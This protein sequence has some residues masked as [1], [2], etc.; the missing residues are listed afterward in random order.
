M[1]RARDE[2]LAGPALADDEHRNVAGGHAIDQAQEI[3][4]RLAPAGDLVVAIAILGAFAGELELGP[5]GLELGL[6]LAEQPLDADTRA[7]GPARGATQQDRVASVGDGHGRLR[8]DDADPR[9]LPRPERPLSDAIVEVHDTERLAAREE[10]HGEYATQAQ[11]V[12]ARV[13][14]AQG[15]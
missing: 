14:V 3:A 2:L 9:Q 7:L 6:A 13:R 15:R 5:R 10:R 4:H 11:R 1:D 12:D 8:R